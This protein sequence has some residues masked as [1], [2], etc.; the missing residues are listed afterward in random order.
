MVASDQVS[1]ATRALGGPVQSNLSMQRCVLVQVQGPESGQSHALGSRSVVVGKSPDCDICLAD[2]TVSRRH[3]EIVHEGDRFL[4]RDLGSTNGTLLDGAEVKEAFLR[5][6][7]LIQAGEV[8]LRFQT[9][10]DPVQVEPSDRESFGGLLGVSLRMREIFSLLERVAATENTVLLQGETGTGKGEA[11]RAIHDNSGRRRGPLVV[12]DCGAV[13]RTLIESE[14]FGHVRGAF[15]GANASRKGA[16]EICRGGTLF[17]DELDDLPWEL[18]PKLLRALEERE[19][20]RLGSGQTAKFDARVV[21]ASKK[22]LWQEVQEGRFRQDLYFRISVVTIKLP[23]LRERREDIGLLVDTFADGRCP[24]FSQWSLEAQARWLDHAWPGNVR[25]LRNAV[26]RALALGGPEQVG[27]P[28][29]G[30]VSPTPEHGSGLSPE[31]QLPFKEAKERL[32]NEFER[33]Y[34]RRLLAHTEGGVTGAARR[35]GIDRKHLYK[36]LEKHGLGRSEV[37][38]KRG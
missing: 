37:K 16:L 27:P 24:P 26:E 4:L 31:Y 10:F 18:Q 19:F 15:T 38:K 8:A 23:S 11:A 28:G 6:G 1:M 29:V 36:L 5:P 17:I 34:L 3:F 20:Q 33:E 25:E 12:V 22:D 35:A 9:A 7:M 30:K 2:V 13:A 21:A 14:L 32:L